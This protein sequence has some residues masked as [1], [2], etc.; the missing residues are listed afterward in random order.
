[1]LVSFACVGFPF[2]LYL[3]RIGLVR[4]RPVRAIRIAHFSFYNPMMSA[5]RPE[6]R[7]KLIFVIHKAKGYLKAGIT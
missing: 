6:V 3:K 5:I 7:R 1:M 2:V 4:F